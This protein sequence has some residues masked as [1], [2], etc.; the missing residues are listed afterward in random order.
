MA[1]PSQLVEL[2]RT[3]FLLF[4]REP[5][6]IFWV[7]V[8]PIVLAVV[9]GLAFHSGNV[10]PSPVG[11]VRG[12]I[13]TAVLDSLSS[14]GDLD[15]RTFPTT[16]AALAKLRVGA[17]DLVVERVDGE[18][19]LRSDP[20]R[21]EGEL[22]RLRVQGVW[23]TGGQLSPSARSEPMTQAGSRYIDFLLPGLLGMNL[24]S[25]GIWGTGFAIVD[26]RQKKLLRLLRVTPMRRTRFLLAQMLSRILFL[27]AEV[28]VI[29]AFG[30]FLLGVPMRGDLFSLLALCLFGGVTF[31][32]LGLWVASRATTIEGVSGLMNFVMMPMWLGSGVFFSYERFPE[33][34]HP[35]LRLIPLTALNDALRAIMIEGQSLWTLTPELLVQAVW[36]AVAYF[37]ALRMFRWQ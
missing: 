13:G 4:I 35:V 3:R 6:A 9:L 1:R 31:S 33:F 16:K 22:A 34:L 14:A 2:T 25:T 36:M 17:I 5:E 27:L 30:V 12:A 10:K 23:S 26:M 24:M 32:G 7:F 29:L 11:V 28:G 15:V 19:V 37:A 8:F 18:L 20:R 21:T